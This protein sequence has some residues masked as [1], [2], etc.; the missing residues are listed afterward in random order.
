MIIDRFILPCYLF[1]VRRLVFKCSQGNLTFILFNSI[2]IISLLNEC[3]L[4]LTQL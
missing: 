2:F 4:L 1:K 3:N